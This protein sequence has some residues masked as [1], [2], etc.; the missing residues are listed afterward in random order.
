MKIPLYTIGHGNRSSEIFAEL[1]RQYTI[2]FLVDIRSQPYSRYAPQFS[3]TALVQRLAQQNIHYLFLGDLLGGRPADETCYVNGH[4]D[5]ARVRE[6]AFFRQGIARLRTAWEKQLRVAIMC[7]EAKPQECHRSKLIGN[8]LSE[9]HIEVAHIDE[10]GVLKTQQ[11]LNLQL[12][13]GQLPLFSDLPL[14]ET[15]GKIGRSR[16]TYALL[17]KEM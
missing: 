10:L 5:Y 12:S 7:S 11:E 8:V 15:A 6:K 13:D 2:A 17:T 4:V 3:Q 9:Q 1:L 14:V 16:K